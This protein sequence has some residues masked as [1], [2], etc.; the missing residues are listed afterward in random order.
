MRA[1]PHPP[2]WPCALPPWGHPAAD[3]PLE[4]EIDRLVSALYGTPAPE[5]AIVE[6][7][8]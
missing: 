3:T 4:A 1:P 2:P 8:S 5:T 6:G 7:K